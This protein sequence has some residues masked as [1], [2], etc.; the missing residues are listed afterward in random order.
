MSSEMLLE[1]C[2]TL[3]PSLVLEAIKKAVLANK[4]T[5]RYIE[6]ILRNW[7]NK[8]FKKLIDVKNEEEE[9]KK[10]KEDSAQQKETEEEKMQRKIKALEEDLKNANK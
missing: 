1:Y 6:G 7:E 9:F 4:R 8:G 2:D 10:S 3:S 5:G